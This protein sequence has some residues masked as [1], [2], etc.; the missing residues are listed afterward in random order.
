MADTRRLFLFI[1]PKTT[2]KCQV[3]PSFLFH[4]IFVCME[5][6]Q[7]FSHNAFCCSSTRGKIYP[8]SQF[9]LKIIYWCFPGMSFSNPT[10]FHHICAFCRHF[11]ICLWKYQ[12]LFW[13]ANVYPLLG[14]ICFWWSTWYHNSIIY[15]SNLNLFWVENKYLISYS[16]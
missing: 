7:F 5:A 16:N 14:T 8:Y 1:F 10:F 6:N 2:V 13:G 11:I 9:S 3:R 4:V 12:I 15:R